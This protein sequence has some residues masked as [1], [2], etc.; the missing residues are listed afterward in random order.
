MFSAVLGLS[1]LLSLGLGVLIE[2]SAQYVSAQGLPGSKPDPTSTSVGPSPA[3]S[4]APTST[5]KPY[6][7]INITR[8]QYEEAHNRWLAKGVIEYEASIS[9]V[10]MVPC[11]SDVRVEIGKKI[12]II[13]SNEYGFYPCD[14]IE[15][16]FADIDRRLNGISGADQWT[17][18]IVG[19]NQALGYPSSII[20]GPQPGI[21]VTDLYNSTL[22]ADLRILRTKADSNP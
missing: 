18:W 11:A 1:V 3:T 12:E 22:V 15:G 4:K 2:E 20:V 9:R 14:T 13:G 5:P 6:P 10:S 17:Y 16:L 8:A 21:Q 19:F 7:P